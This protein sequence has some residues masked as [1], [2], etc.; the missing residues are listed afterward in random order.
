MTLP[1]A[2]GLDG[3]NEW[4]YESLEDMFKVYGL[5]QGCDLDSWEH[6][7]TPYDGDTSR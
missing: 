5:E 4:I 2:G 1:P 3:S 6:V 7:K